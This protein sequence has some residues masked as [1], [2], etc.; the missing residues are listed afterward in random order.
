MPA[1][2]TVTSDPYGSEKVISHP[3]CL[4]TAFSI[5]EGSGCRDGRDTQKE[6][7]LTLCGG[8][9]AE[10]AGRSNSALQADS[11]LRTVP[12]RFANRT[13]PTTKRGICW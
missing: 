9:G 2:I 11:S 7:T 5:P 8:Q 4:P 1:G 6:R 12:H 10:T 13:W 3:S